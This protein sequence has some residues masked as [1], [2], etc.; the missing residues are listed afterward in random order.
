L[1]SLFSA[2]AFTQHIDKHE[3][4]QHLNHVL[5]SQPQGLMILCAHHQVDELDFLHAVLPS[6]S[7]P[8]FGGIFPS[9]LFQTQVHEQGILIA[10]LRE[11]IVVEHQR[12]ISQNTKLN[13]TLA[14]GFTQCHSVLVLVDGLSRNIDAYLQRLFD[15]L[16]HQVKVVGGGAGFMSF[17]QQA[18][19]LSNQGL[20]VDSFLVV[21]MQQ[22]WELAI[23]H[24]WEPLAGPF[25]ANLV[26]DNRIIELNFQS[27]A[28][29]Y[30]ETVEQ[31]SELSFTDDDFFSIA[32]TYPFGL[33][34][35]DDDMLVRDPITRDGDSLV[36]VGKI[37][38]H[39]MLY[40]LQGQAQ[41][42]IAASVNAVSDVLTK[43][44]LS[45]E[46]GDALIFDCISRKLFLQEE[47]SA[48]LRGISELFP[49][50]QQSMGAL[51]LGEIATGLSG[52]INFHN[53]TAVT[54]VCVQARCE[55]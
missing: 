42:L 21:G 4:V 27:A 47:F 37:P 28:Q 33:A 20:L 55:S 8:V 1:N 26:D 44:Q 14:D 51:V 32:K 40:I 35:L 12:E 23:G 48:E 6:L 31:H 7:L 45:S 25:L 16:G 54:A 49:T 29:V 18:C 46:F 13:F 53:K 34:R 36:C 2:V 10:G 15:L 43:H 38:E 52:S 19:L 11:H 3:F 39:T 24:G 30:Q 17:K 50:P 5:A 41:G 22:H 9:V